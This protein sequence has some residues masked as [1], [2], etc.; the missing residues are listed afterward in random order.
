LAALG[1]ASAIAVGTSLAD[2]S[3][4]VAGELTARDSAFAMLTAINVRPPQSAVCH[5]V[6]EV[7]AALFPS[8][9]VVGY[10]FA[11]ADADRLALA[12]DPPP[13]SATRAVAAASQAG[14]EASL[15]RV[16]LLFQTREAIA[17]EFGADGC[18]SMTRDLGLDEMGRVFEQA[19]VRAPFGATFYQSSGRAI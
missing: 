18:H 5:R 12:M 9:A 19:G 8:Q 11:G 16:V 15:I 17:F 4:A 3:Q 6:D 10:D 2:G 1:L 14:A 7:S 13:P